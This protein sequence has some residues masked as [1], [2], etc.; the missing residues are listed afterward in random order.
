MNNSNSHSM[1]IY[2]IAVMF[3]ILLGCTQR[4]PLIT[5]NDFYNQEF[6]P[7]VESDFPFISTYL[8]AREIGPHFPTDNVVSR[9]LIVNLD[10]S[11]FM[12]FDRDLLRWSIA[13]TGGRLTES[14]LPEVSYRDFFNKLSHVP[15]IAGNPVFS[16]GISPGWSS[17]KPIR[18]DIR[19]PS[20]EM[21]GSHWGRC[22]VNT[23]VGMAFT[24]MATRQSSPI[25]YQVRTSRSFRA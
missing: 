20:Q 21:E 10:D 18:Q 16:N 1:G 19:P 9:G 5:K 3:L 14:M 4:T 2:Q 15:K 7:Y 23:D 11:A 24:S 17:K 25:A 12:C 22:R 8:D 13:W 6:N